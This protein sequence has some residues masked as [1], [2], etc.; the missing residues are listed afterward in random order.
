[1]RI[2]SKRMK[3]IRIDHYVTNRVY[4]N[5][6]RFRAALSCFMSAPPIIVG[7]GEILWDLLP[8]G[9]QLGGAP[10]NFAYCAHLLGNRAMI[11]SRIGTDELGGDVRNRLRHTGLG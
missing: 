4:E 2:K 11:A 7:L 3:R 6:R 5:S 8:S 1:M 9:R 10:A